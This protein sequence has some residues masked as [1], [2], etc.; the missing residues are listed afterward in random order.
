[1]ACVSNIPGG[2][3]NN[4]SAEDKKKSFAATAVESLAAKEFGEGRN[5]RTRPAIRVQVG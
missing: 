1:M 2:W 3:F 5:K 4:M